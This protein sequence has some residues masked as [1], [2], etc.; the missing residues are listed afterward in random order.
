MLHFNQKTKKKRRP[1]VALAAGAAL[2]ATAALL[3]IGCGGKT[4]AGGPGAGGGPPAMPVQVQVA[5]SVRIPDTTEYL[6]VLK[7]RQSAVINPQVE[8]QVTKIFVKSGD[9]VSEGTPLLQIDPLKQEATLNSQAATL[10]AQE[11]NLRLAKVQL[12]RAQKLYAAG[13]TSK[14]DFDNAQSNYDAIAAQVKALEQQVEQQ[15]V[16]LHYYK[17]SAPAEGIVG[18]IPVHVGDRVTV[19]TLLTTVNLPGALE[20][21]IYVPAD[22]AKDL[23]LGLPVRLLGEHGETV[24]DT[25]ITFVS[26][27]VETDTQTVLAKAAIENAKDRL[28]IAQ[29][30]RAQVTWGSH[31]GPVVPVL[32]VLRI[33]GQAF[34]FVAV[35]EGNGTVARQKLL[36]LGDTTGDNYAVLDGLKAGDHVILSGTQFLQDGAP[37]M[38]QIAANTPQQG[39]GKS[40]AR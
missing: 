34:V 14:Q 37:V 4:S 11:A 29:Q 1:A 22:R 40:A 33:N 12:E 35:K 32:A 7:S 21:Y 2:M 38:E 39:D 30:V 18:D 17:V 24:S 27:Q 20:A 23:R 31:E 10:T 36:K 15:K 3:A 8:G 16:E 9:Q 5:Q 19:T 28:R 25:R 6:S 13:V 26:P